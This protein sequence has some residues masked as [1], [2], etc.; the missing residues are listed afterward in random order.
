MNS[1]SA[2]VR[3]HFNS[4]FP[5]NYMTSS[6]T[7]FARKQAEFPWGALIWEVRSVNHRYL[8][9]SFR[10]PEQFRQ[11]EPGLRDLLRKHLSRGKI[12]AQL[13]FIPDFSAS[14]QLAINDALLEELDRAI[15]HVN[16][17]TTTETAAI[18]ALEILKWP[19]IIQ[20]KDQD[21]KVIEEETLALFK[22]A[23]S[24]LTEHR[25]REGGE[26]KTILESRLSAIEAIV[27]DIRTALPD[28]LVAQ[29][30]RLRDQVSTL[31]TEV[32]PG[33]LEQELILIMQK[34][35]IQEEID[36]LDAHVKEI[37]HVLS[38]KEPV[39]R[40][41]DFLMQELNREANT[42]CSKAVVTDTTFNAVELKVLIEQMREQVQNIE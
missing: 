37:R 10:L 7:A 21:A 35:D 2:I 1:K 30:N 5:G 4:L 41:L 9:P 8:E 39:G 13:K 16:A 34:A 23:L 14:G 26:L 18:N 28:I 33:R 36:R 19:G 24:L 32:E 6:M 38:R 31:E 3:F 42:I 17:R 15:S 27:L 20:E 11:L 29:Q 40:R 12:D 22:G 25:N